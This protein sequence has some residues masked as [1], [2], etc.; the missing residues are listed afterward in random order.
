MI[1]YLDQCLLAIHYLQW[2]SERINEKKDYILNHQVQKYIWGIILLRY[3]STVLV[4][5]ARMG[6]MKGV[7]KRNEDTF[8][9]ERERKE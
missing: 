1:V 8:E 9:R 6:L 7:M 3:I 2:P 5:H 4:F